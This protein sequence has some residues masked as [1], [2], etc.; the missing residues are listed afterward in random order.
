MD[1]KI[2]VIVPVYNVEKYLKKCIESILK[3]TYKNLDIILVDDGSTDESGKICKQYEAKDNRIRVISQNNMG[4]SAARN[5]GIDASKGDYIA[6]VDSDDWIEYDMYEILINSIIN[7]NADIAISSTRNIDESNNILGDN[8]DLINDDIQIFNKHDMMSRYLLGGWIPAWDKLYK[9]ELFNN[10]KFPVGKI[11]EDEAI[12]LKILD[13]TTRIVVNNNA[14]YNYLKRPMSITTSKFSRKKFDWLDNSYNN[15]QYI[16]SNY[17][18]ITLQAE[19]R[20]FKCINSLIDQI[21]FGNYNGFEN[22]LYSMRKNVIRNIHKILMNPYL[23]IK[24]KINFTIL[25][26]NTNIYKIIKSKYKSV[27]YSK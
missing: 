22:D 15:L 5:T 19:S 27:K 7:Y 21:I 20:Y 3:Q 12:M 11:N 26:I 10:I 14:V 4:L 16:K 23:S 25:G 17:P 18:N 24:N 2:S 6:F 9:K 1:Y 13:R 8:R